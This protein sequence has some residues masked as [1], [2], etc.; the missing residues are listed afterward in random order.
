VDIRDRLLLIEDD[1]LS[2]AEA[3]WTVAG[4]ESGVHSRALAV[5]TNPAG[6]YL[7]AGYT[8]AELCKPEGELWRYEPGGALTWQKPLG[9]LGSDL[10]GPHAL[11]WSPAGHVVV[12]RGKQV[13]PKWVFNVEAFA[14]GSLGPPLWSFKP[15]NQDGNQ[16]ALDL[17]VDACGVIY[18][19][20]IS[21]DNFPT[22]AAVT[23]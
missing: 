6:E 13:G 2:G 8:C 18:A 14:P 4:P 3:T 1:V 10:F 17:A 15:L 21:L 11:A 5:A 19:V 7:L 23:P 9:V 20:G 12:A 16:L 22:F